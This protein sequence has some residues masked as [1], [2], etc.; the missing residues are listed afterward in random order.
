MQQ[1]APHKTKLSTTSGTHSILAKRQT[2]ARRTAD[3]D[4][5]EAEDAHVMLVIL[6]ELLF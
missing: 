5:S 3:N 2:L 1:C 6:K 4:T